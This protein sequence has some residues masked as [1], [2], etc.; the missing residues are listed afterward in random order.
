MATGTGTRVRGIPVEA[1]T[2]PVLPS[3]TS[4]PPVIAIGVIP[5]RAVEGNVALLWAFRA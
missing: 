5:H 2:I 3:M 1:E 4:D